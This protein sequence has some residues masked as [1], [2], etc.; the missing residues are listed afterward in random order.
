[1][2]IWLFFHL[3]SVVDAEIH[4]IMEDRITDPVQLS[5]G[6][7]VTGNIVSLADSRDLKYYL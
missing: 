7:P 1:M 2:V 5:G 3:P 4:V 6:K